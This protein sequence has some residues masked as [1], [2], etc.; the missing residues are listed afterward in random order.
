MRRLTLALA[1]LLLAANVSLCAQQQVVPLWP[2]PPATSHSPE[3]DL[4]PDPKGAY[5]VAIRLT[6]V[7]NP[8]LTLFPPS[9]S[10]NL[11]AAVAI[12]PGGGYRILAWDLEGLNGC[13]WLNSIGFTC[14]LV[15]YRVPQ[16]TRYPQSYESLEDGQQAVR[17]LRKH[18]SEWGFNPNKIGIIGF[19]AG[20]HLAATLLAHWD[21][22]HALSTPAA[23]DVDAT[24]TA[25]PDF[26]ILGYPAYCESSAN[27]AL[28]DPALTPRPG[29][30]PVF[31]VAAEDDHHYINSALACYRGFKDANV[32]A[33]LH[34]FPTGEHGFGFDPPHAAEAHWTALA[35]D[36]LRRSGF[37]P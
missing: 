19:S 31:I 15:K 12:F 1:P 25:R 18:A 26:A 20:G 24:I 3:K 32:P 11:H 10:R 7:A 21:G 29:A 5:P 34:L 8:T 16:A 37:L 28:I 17:L 6:D 14:A 13:R 36:W 27:P 9:G 2:H 23:A 35:E 22:D 30:P 4:G 33:E